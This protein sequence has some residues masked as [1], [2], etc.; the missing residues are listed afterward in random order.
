MLQHVIMDKLNTFKHYDD[1]HGVI[2]FGFF[3]TLSR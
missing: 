3:V 2:M 1:D